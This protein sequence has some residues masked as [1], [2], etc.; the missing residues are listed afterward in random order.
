MPDRT[1]NTLLGAAKALTDVVRPS[2]DAADPLA[3]EQLT[4]VVDYLRIVRARIDHLAGR[5]RLELRHALRMTER[6]L[7]LD[8]PALAAARSSTVDL[9]QAGAALLAEPGATVVRMRSAAEA[10]R[11]RL[12]E[13]IRD[14]RRLAPGSRRALFRIVLDVSGDTLRF[15]RSWYLPWGFD[16]EP[17]DV[18]PIED[19]LEL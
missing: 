9:Q 12:T 3:A 10:V 6:V 11:Q 14:S 16:P 4:L 17:A 15:E 13:I 18:L 8:D 19:A 7:A 1:E 2:V 5:E